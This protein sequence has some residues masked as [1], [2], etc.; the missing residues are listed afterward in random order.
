MKKKCH[1]SVLCENLPNGGKPPATEDEEDLLMFLVSKLGRESASG[2]VN[3][4]PATLP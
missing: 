3:L 1:N 2:V 4:L